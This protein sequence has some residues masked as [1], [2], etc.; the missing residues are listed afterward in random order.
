MMLCFSNVENT[1]KVGPLLGADSATGVQVISEHWSWRNGR[2]QRE[3]GGC[4]A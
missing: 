3:Y 4:G 1:A 2:W